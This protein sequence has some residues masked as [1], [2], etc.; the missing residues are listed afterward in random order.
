MELLT[1]GIGLIFWQTVVFSIVFLFLLTFAWRPI[2]DALKTR[3]SFIN[4]ALRAAELAKEEMAQLKQ[5]NELLLEEARRE[6]DS[7]L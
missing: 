5:D 1:P 6:R 2:A 7:M 3:E 4:D